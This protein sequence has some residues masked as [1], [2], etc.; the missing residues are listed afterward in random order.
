MTTGLEHV[1]T[2]DLTTVVK[3]TKAGI[4]RAIDHHKEHAQSFHIGIT[5]LEVLEKELRVRGED[6]SDSKFGRDIIGEII[7]TRIDENAQL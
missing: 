3:K 6:P 4:L 1:S 7:Q 2:E 5:V